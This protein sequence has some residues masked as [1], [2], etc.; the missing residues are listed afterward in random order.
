MLNQSNIEIEVQLNN[1][2]NTSMDKAITCGLI[3]NEL[4]TNSYKHA[5]PDG[6]GKITISLD[7]K[8][9]KMELTIRDNGIGIENHILENR[10]TFGFD[11]IDIMIEQ[12]DG[13]IIT[14]SNPGSG[15]KHQISCS[16][17]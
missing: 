15:T 9:D 13:N 5:F 8:G 2:I 11:L 3:I 12:L 16:C 1:Q 17:L 7:K 14:T 4:L 10:N 6:Q